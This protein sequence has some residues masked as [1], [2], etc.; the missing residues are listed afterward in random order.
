MAEAHII[1][2]A[3]LIRFVLISMAAVITGATAQIIRHYYK[4]YRGAMKRGDFRGILPMHV[5]MIGSSYMLLVFGAVS[6]NII[7]IGH[8]PNI[9]LALNAAAFPLGVTALSLIHRYEYRQVRHGELLD[10]R[11]AE[12]HSI[13]DLTTME[14]RIERMHQQKRGT[15]A[16]RRKSDHELTD[17]DTQAQEEDRD[18]DQEDRD[19]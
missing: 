6:Q 13:A 17:A 18:E 3:D 14:F 12:G 16:Q 19:A 2:V 11:I 5:W 9:Y 15:N 4:A 8:D 10:R 7:Q 1:F